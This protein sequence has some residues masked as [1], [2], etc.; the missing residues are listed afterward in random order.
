MPGGIAQPAPRRSAPPESAA[1]SRVPRAAAPATPALAVAAAPAAPHGAATTRDRLR[2]SFAADAPPPALATVPAAPDP[3]A[4]GAARAVVVPL[5]PA[6]AEPVG[7]APAAEAEPVG[8]GPAPAADALTTRDRIRNGARVPAAA[9]AEP[10]VAQRTAQVIEIDELRERRR[11]RIEGAPPP[12]ADR[13]PPAP[14]VSLA[15]QPPARG[16]PGGTGSAAVSA[17]AP[18]ATDQAVERITSTP[19]APAPAVEGLVVPAL[20]VAEPRPDAALARAAA[21]EPAAAATK[22]AAAPATTEPAAVPTAA[23]ANP[24]AAAAAKLAAAPAAPAAAAAEPVA[25]A[26]PAAAPATAASTEP[27]AAAGPA[28]GTGTAPVSAGATESAAAAEPAAAVDAAAAAAPAAAAQTPAAEA[29]AAAEPAAAQA[30]AAPEAAAAPLVIRNPEDE[31]GFQAMKQRARRAGSATKEHQP[32]AE[33]AATAQGAALP[34]END[35]ESQAAAAQVEVMGEQEPGVFD[36]QAFIAAVKAAVE[37]ATPKNLEQADEFKESG[38]VGKA[39]A[40]VGGLVEGGKA[41]SEHDIQAATQAA[42][43]LSVATPKPVDDMV[44]DEPGAPVAGVGAA[45]AMPGPRPPEQ[46]DLSAGP[47]KVDAELAAANVTDEQVARS[48][49]PD[50]SAALEARQKARDHAAT[51]PGEYRA[52]EEAT[53][54]QGREAA[55]GNAAAQLEGMH[56]A[57][58]GTLDGVLGEKE[59]TKSTHETEHARIAAELQ[60]IYDA[61]HADVTT[62]L[63][64]LDVKVDDE[65]T[66]GEKA[67]RTRFENDV[68]DR[69]RAYKADRYGGLGGGARWAWDKLTG[70]PDEVN[71]F[72]EEG[73]DAYLRDMDAVIEGIANTVGTQL[74]AARARI[75]EG[76]AEVRAYVE[77]LPENQR[78]I[79][80]EAQGKLEDRFDELSAEVDAKQDALVDAVAKRYVESRDALDARIEELQSANKGLVAAALDAVVGVIKTIIALGEMLLSVL[81]KAAEVVGDIIADPVGFLGNLIDGV[82]GGLK[83]FVARIATHLQNALVEWLFGTLG[84]VGITLP[85]KL[86]GAG[87][88]DLVTQILGLT[89]ANIR[90]RV[91]RAVGEPVVAHMEGAVDVFKTLATVGVGGLWEFIRDKVGDLQ[92]TVLGKIKEWVIERVIKGGIEWILGLLTP[93]GAFIKACKAI[94]SI[95]MFIVD[96]AKQIMEFVNSILDSIS[97]IAKGDVG[98]AVEKVEGS[99]AKALPLAIGFLAGLLNIGGVSEKVKTIIAAV[100]RPVEKAID[101]LVMGIARTFKRTFGGAASFVTKKIDAGKAWTKGKVEAGKEWAKG[102]AEALKPARGVPAQPD[103]VAAAPEEHDEA[104]GGAETEPVEGPWIYETVE[105][106][107]AVRISQTFEVFSFSRATRVTGTRAAAIAQKNLE[108]KVPHPAATYPTDSVGRAS[109]PGGFIAGLKDGAA[110]DQIPAVKK[111]PGGVAAYEPGD[112]RGHLIGDRFMGLAI[113]GNIV[114]MHTTL[115]GSTFLSFETGIANDYKAARA[116]NRGALLTMQFTPNYPPDDPTQPG[117]KY[118]PNPVDADCTL[119][120]L[121]ATGGVTQKG[122]TGSFPN[123][124]NATIIVDLNSASKTEILAAYSGQLS[125]EIHQ[126]VD[127][128][129]AVRPRRTVEG[130]L[131]EL[132]LRL[133]AHKTYLFQTLLASRA[134]RFVLR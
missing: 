32:A 87:I 3:A 124:S 116:A 67:A 73:R 125:P 39:T 80:E 46:T 111:L 59:D 99:L 62:I 52:E 127:A 25:A 35:L 102:K 4:P 112:V 92:E 37:A 113:D 21:A 44:N 81:A 42:P 2:A 18:P 1:R 5:V 26:G 8:L 58:T 79:G 31:P 115:N 128:I 133:P 45:G 118:R 13:P 36:A 48:N 53:L 76:R 117:R 14:I 126:L 101:F 41:S 65:F 20:A 55:A 119:Y 27:A 98:A 64:G 103:P 66:R 11:Q 50:F 30:A 93:V 96:R 123:P 83:R 109:G 24:A 33:G 88:L 121:D 19:P 131:M 47:A 54:A 71:S 104:P 61:A 43:D 94:Y 84:S 63:D 17:R 23:A 7:P 9:A 12:L 15:V 86:D 74:T 29:P 78:T 51:A 110:R 34:P 134:A 57:R 38:T 22:P 89:Y 108:S 132:V 129:I 91:A 100:R 60:A 130:F 95:V 49:E 40:E 85:D 114:P 28:G 68:D 122:Y 105:Q 10:A 106:G 90:A 16:P 97:A 75:V 72:Y 70:M 77:A 69:M 6:A 107:H 82:M 56:G 120:Q